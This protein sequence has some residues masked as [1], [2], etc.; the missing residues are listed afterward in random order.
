M[1]LRM[2]KPC[3]QFAPARTKRGDRLRAQEVGGQCG[4]PWLSVEVFLV[5]CDRRK[6]SAATDFEWE[7]CDMRIGGNRDDQERVS[8]TSA[9]PANNHCATLGRLERGHAQ[10]G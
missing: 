5:R 7:C 8:A 2:L 3:D 1:D 4:Y 9:L 10:C 6:K